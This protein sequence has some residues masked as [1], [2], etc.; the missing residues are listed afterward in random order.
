MDNLT[1]HQNL[2]SPDWLF[3]TCGHDVTPRQQLDKLELV[4]SFGAHVTIRFIASERVGVVV[5]RL[6]KRQYD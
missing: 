2:R 1:R 5:E 3:T 4:S 6:M